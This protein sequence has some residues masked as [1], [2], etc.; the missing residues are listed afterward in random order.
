[1]KYMIGI[2]YKYTSPSNKVYI[3]QTIHEHTRYMRHKRTEGD[4]KFH[5]AIKKYGFENFTYEVIFTIDNDDRKRVKEKLDFMERYYIRKYDSLNN[6]YN[7]TAGGEGGRGTKHTEEFKQKI[8]ERM[9]EN[10]PAWNMTDEWRKHIGDSQRGKKMSDNMRKL[11]SERM[12]SNNPMKNPE[13]AAKMSASQ[14]G[15]HLSE[16]HK[17]KISESSKGRIFSED[18][19][20]KMSTASKN[21]LRDAKGHFIKNNQAQKNE[22]EYDKNII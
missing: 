15:K 21:R 8:S 13:V 11:T 1:M 17:K 20:S 6:G 14:K 9:K 19:K 18:T 5:R 2:I 3:G 12:K 7:L 4:N 22:Q 10:N 16:E